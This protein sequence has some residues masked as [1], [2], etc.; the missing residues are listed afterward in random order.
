[1]R[2]IFLQWIHPALRNARR[3]TLFL[4][5]SQNWKR[6]WKKKIE[7]K[8]LLDFLSRRRSATVQWLN[9]SAF[10]QRQKDF[11][12]R[13]PFRKNVKKPD[14]GF[15]GIK[16]INNGTATEYFPIKKTLIKKKRHNSIPP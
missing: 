12:N 16:T 7:R 10:T 1:M 2:Q 11:D 15:E 13:C 14:I 8:L 5:Q 4:R 6:K 9:F 3:N